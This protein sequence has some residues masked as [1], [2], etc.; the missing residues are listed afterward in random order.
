ML[1]KEHSLRVFENRVLGRMFGP[2]R[3][4]VLGGWRNLLN[5]E[6]HNL[7]MIKSR[8]IRWT[9]HVARIRAEGECI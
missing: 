6:L 7:M 8:I 3:Y 4:E 2:K 1:R 5:E 9:W